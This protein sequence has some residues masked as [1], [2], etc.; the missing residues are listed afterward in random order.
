MEVC[1][2]RPDPLLPVT[3]DR[4]RSLAEAGRIPVWRS[5]RASLGDTCYT[6]LVGA[7][8]YDDDKSATM[9]FYSIAIEA[10]KTQIGLDGQTHG[11]SVVLFQRDLATKDLPDGFEKRLIRDVVH[12]DKQSRVVRFDVGTGGYEYSLPGP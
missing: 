11:T 9:A 8:Y 12:F 4:G 10:W 1:E 7:S 2:A 6:A 3:F 5:Q